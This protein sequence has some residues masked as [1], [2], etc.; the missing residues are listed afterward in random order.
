M[1]SFGVNNSKLLLEEGPAWGAALQFKRACDIF[2]DVSFNVDWFQQEQHEPHITYIHHIYIYIHNTLHTT[3]KHLLHTYNTLYTCTI[4]RACKHIVRRPVR[5][6][7]IILRSIIVATII[8]TIT[9]IIIIVIIV[10]YHILL[11]SL[12]LLLLFL[13]C[14]SG[15]LRP[16]GHAPADAAGHDT[17]YDINTNYYNA[18][19]SNS[20][21]S[22][23]NCNRWTR[24]YI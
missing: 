15:V 11:L 20:N 16:G 13:L 2:V 9:I 21:T 8:T 24:Y 4:M 14:A 1:N 18:N 12:L 6:A 7:A 17:M 23:T 3:C 22:G 10:I 5:G 19:S